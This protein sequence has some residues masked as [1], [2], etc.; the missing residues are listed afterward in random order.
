MGRALV[1]FNIIRTS[2]LRV[3]YI[4][5]RFCR[6]PRVLLAVPAL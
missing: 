4:A 2:R 3:S 5:G 6:P 1:T